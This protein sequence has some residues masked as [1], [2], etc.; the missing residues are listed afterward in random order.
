MYIILLQSVVLGINDV[1]DG[2][3]SSQLEGYL[4]R[5]E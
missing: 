4:S 2:V 1:K 5:P 3:F